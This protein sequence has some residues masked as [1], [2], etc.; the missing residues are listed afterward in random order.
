MSARTTDPSGREAHQSD[1]EAHEGDRGATNEGA[2]LEEAPPGQPGSAGAPRSEVELTVRAVVAGCLIGGVLSLSNI[3]AGLKI[4]WGFNMSITAMLLAFAFFRLTSKRPFGML[5]NN[6]NQTG[7][8]AAASISSAGLVAP[9]PAYT[10]LTGKTLSYF[11]LVV[12]T[13]AVSLV[14]VVVAIGLRKQMI[15]VDKLP[16]PGGVAS[17]ET[18]KQIYAHGKEAMDRVRA[19]A[20]GA[21]AGALVKL[22]AHFAKLHPWGLPGAIGAKTAAAGTSSYSFANL[23]LS[24]DPS[25]LMLGIGGIIGLRAGISLA[26]GA[27]GSWAIL[28][29]IALDAGWAQPGK[30]DPSAA[31]FGAVNKWMLWP[32]VAMMVASSL[33]SFAFGYKSIVRALTGGTPAEGVVEEKADE[34]PRK[35]FLAGIAIV[36]ILATVPQVAFFGIPLWLAVGSVL[37]TFV[38]AVV[39]G[40]VS[41]ETGITP[42]GPMGKVTQLVFGALS[43][44]DV[45]GNLMAA[46]VTGGAA[47]QVGDLLH[48]MKCG[49]LIGA[50]P[51][52]Q[53][54]SQTAGVLAGAICGS[55]GYLVLVPDPKGMLLTNEWPAPAVAAWKAVAEVFREG[56]SAMPPMAVEAMA[57]AAVLGIVLAVLEKVLPPKAVQW[58]PSPGSI[59]LA[60]VVPAWNAL[61]MFFGAV[62]AAVITK[63]NPAWA[64]R[65]MIV[66]AAGLIAGE[67]LVG[68]ALAIW[69][70]VSGIAGG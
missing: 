22:T 13:A 26:I 43:P 11:E 35:V 57:V 12:W 33:T 6:I 29:P 68:V 58:V 69:E 28:A 39:A 36:V 70:T 34:V 4:G 24:L 66:V 44:G 52:R 16:F 46:N 38:L 50:S 9:I 15:V 5:E 30:L 14:G 47:S 63:L 10:I 55:A 67:S 60:M 65:L 56:F 59:G 45:A 17:A 20:L 19:L 51:R 21:L 61:S 53:A 2:E 54:I 49:S 7:A 40:R 48:D 31:W 23:G 8:S 64:K 27:I 41:G 1:P 32:G 3:Y 62:I 25:V 37:F 42:V 18:I